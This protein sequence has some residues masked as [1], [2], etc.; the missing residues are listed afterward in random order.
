MSAKLLTFF[1]DKIYQQKKISLTYFLLTLFLIKFCQQKCQQM[2]ADI[3]A[4][5]ILSET[6]AS[7]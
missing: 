5:K 7:L 2:L 4:D 6:S 1:A 3:F